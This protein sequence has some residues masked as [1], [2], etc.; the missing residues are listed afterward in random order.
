MN[1]PKYRM[2]MDIDADIMDAAI[3]RFTEKT[4]S[5]PERLTMRQLLESI[6]VN[7]AKS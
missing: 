5:I 2:Q 3:K 7:Y 6:L 1:R 4:G